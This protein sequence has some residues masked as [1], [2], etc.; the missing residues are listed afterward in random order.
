MLNNWFY[1]FGFIYLV[2]LIQNFWTLFR[3]PEGDAGINIERMD[4]AEVIELNETIHSKG[5][6]PVLE[7]IFEAFCLIWA[8]I[9]FYY[10]APEMTWFLFDVLLILTHN[11]FLI[12]FGLYLGISAHF[13]HKAKVY[14]TPPKK[15]NNGRFVLA[16]TIGVAELITVTYI[17]YH[18]F[19]FHL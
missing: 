9:G 11:A 13:R 10:A 4:M 14:N 18:H 3:K 12:C 1:S 15:E 2:Y 8:F 7:W 5:K 19:I 6:S 17:L 16:K